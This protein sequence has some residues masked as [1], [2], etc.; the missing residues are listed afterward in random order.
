MYAK[1]CTK[2]IFLFRKSL[3]GLLFPQCNPRCILLRKSSPLKTIRLSNNSGFIPEHG[4]SLGANQEGDI[5]F[6]C[7]NF[8]EQFVVEKSRLSILSQSI[9]EQ[10]SCNKLAHCPCMSCRI[11]KTGGELQSG[12]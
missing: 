2:S 6:H 9:Y 1:L 4:F 10:L 11:C 5:S 7:R 3:K 12:E 8:V